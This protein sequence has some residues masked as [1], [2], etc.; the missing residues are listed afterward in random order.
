[1]DAA[2]LRP[3]FRDVLEVNFRALV[4]EVCCYR[5]AECANEQ[6]SSRVVSCG[7]CGRR[8]L[9]IRGSEVRILPGASEKPLETAAFLIHGVLHSIAVAPM[10]NVEGNAMRFDCG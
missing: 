4:A 5:G 1:M 3:T 8:L 6:G 2:A 10:G 7:L 9:L